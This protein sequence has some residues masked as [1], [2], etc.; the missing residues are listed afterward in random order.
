MQ[1]LKPQV[2]DLA[3]SLIARPTALSVLVTP[4]GIFDPL[5]NQDRAAAD[6]IKLSIVLQAVQKEDCILPSRLLLK[7]SIVEYSILDGRLIFWNRLWVPKQ[8]RIQLIQ[9]TY[10]SLIYAHPGREG[11]YVILVRQYFWPRIGDDIR[12]F[13]R[14]YDSCGANKAWC[15]KRQGFLKLLLIPDQVWTEILIDFITDLLESEGCTNIVVIIDQL[16]K[17]VVVGTL[18]ELTTE[19]LVAWFLWAYYPYYFL[20]IAIVS[21]R[22]SQFTSAFWKRLYD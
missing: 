5:S 19:A 9:A 3:R 11:L 10:D 12:Q 17:G 18:Q 21:N 2:L 8:L 20:L 7:L 13:V 4:T 15:T 16:S 1:L 14:N 6:N 22:G